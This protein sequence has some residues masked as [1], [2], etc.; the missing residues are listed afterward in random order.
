MLQGRYS[1]VGAHPVM[2]IVAQE[3]KVTVMDHEKGH[4][5]EQVVDD[6]MQVPRSFMEGW[7]PQQI[8]QLPDSFCGEWPEIDD[9][10]YVMSHVM[11]CE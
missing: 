11:K 1:M 5:T 10:A 9:G 4:T 6:P 7:N 8:D 2:E 3:H